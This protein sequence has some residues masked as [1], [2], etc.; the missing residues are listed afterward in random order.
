MFKGFCKIQ[1][2]ESYFLSG[3]VFVEVK[4]L[5]AHFCATGERNTINKSQNGIM[6]SSF[7]LKFPVEQK[8]GRQVFGFSMVF[9]PTKEEGQVL[10]VWI[11]QEIDLLCKRPAL[12]RGNVSASVIR[13]LRG[14][15][16]GALE[17]H[18]LY[19]V[20]DWQQGLS[21]SREPG[22]NTRLICTWR[23]FF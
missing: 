3:W 22:E 9:N 13:R 4:N 18:P 15:T 14:S 17:D 7:S 8:L 11:A 21:R 2:L 1:R 20:K 23:S 16:S 6:E 5:W 12:V 10:D 19:T